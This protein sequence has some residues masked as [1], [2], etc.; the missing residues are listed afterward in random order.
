[1]TRLSGRVKLMLSIGLP[2][3]LLVAFL[4]TFFMELGYAWRYAW[5]DVRAE[6]RDYRDYISDGDR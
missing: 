2:L 1:M 3:V 6:L 4:R 5:Q